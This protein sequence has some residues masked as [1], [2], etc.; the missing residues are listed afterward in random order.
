M[1]DMHTWSN[2]VGESEVLRGDR[3]IEELTIK[4]ENAV[5]FG[6]KRTIVGTF[7]HLSM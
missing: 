5:E 7:M 1:K 2:S 3:M 4:E 6:F